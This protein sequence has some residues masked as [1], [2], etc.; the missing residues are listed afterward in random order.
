MEKNRIILSFN[1]DAKSAPA[2]P[3]RPNR[4]SQ[5]K[6]AESKPAPASSECGKGDGV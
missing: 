5:P 6:A 2:R 4:P 3:R 1:L